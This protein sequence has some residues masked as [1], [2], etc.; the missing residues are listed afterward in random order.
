M[1]ALPVGNGR[2]ASMTIR[3]SLG[4]PC[5]IR[6][7]ERLVLKEGDPGRAGDSTVSLQTRAGSAYVLKPE[8]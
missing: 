7:G 5:R 4:G 8:P 6:A 3:S 1:E 2:L